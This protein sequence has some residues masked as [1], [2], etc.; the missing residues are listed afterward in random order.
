MC[1]DMVSIITPVYNT[2]R[3]LA[4]CIESVLVQKYTDFELLLIDDGS[5]DTSG[6]ICDKYA[7]LDQRIRVFHIVNNGVSHAR[8]IG[9]ENALGEWVLFLDS[10]DWLTEDCLQKCVNAMQKYDV[11]VV[12]FPIS[13][14]DENG[15][16]LFFRNKGMEVCSLQQFVAYDNYSLSTGSGMLNRSMIEKYKIRFDE[17]LTLGEDIVFWLT[18]FSYCKKLMVIDDAVYYYLCCQGNIQR[19]AQVG[20]VTRTIE[21]LILL[22]NEY[23]LYSN[24]CNQHIMGLLMQLLA[25]T[26]LPISDVVCYY[27]KANIDKPLKDRKYELL[28]KVS[29]INCKLV[30]WLGR[31]LL[32]QIHKTEKPML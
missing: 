15:N 3:Y 23:P 28:R 30:F 14:M 1:D 31:I 11:D 12:Q 19:R 24:R 13:C 25:Y 7:K 2:E 18:Y 27:K 17:T 6:Q 8:N 5:T 21:R 10:D 32:M 16:F 4:K 20:S 29:K 22:K 9:L 26:Q